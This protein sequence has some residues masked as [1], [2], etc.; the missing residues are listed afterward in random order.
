MAIYQPLLKVS[1]LE[2]N[3]SQLRDV[4]AAKV[5]LSDPDGEVEEIHALA[6]DTRTPKQIVRDIESLLLVKFD[7]RIDYRCVSLAQVSAQDLLSYFKRPKLMK[8][9]Q[10]TADGLTVEV[11][12][13][14]A[15]GVKAVGSAQT[16]GGA[17]TP[18]RVAAL[19]TLRALSIVAGKIED[20][21][22]EAAETVTLAGRPAAVVHLSWAGNQQEERFLGISFTE[23]DV[24]HGAA[25]ATL[26]AVNRRFF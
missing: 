2:E 20:V 5:I 13:A 4:Y 25:R 15:D 7:T 26:D 11:C 23:P 8:V 19:A 9:K 10:N 3:L 21:E 22:L 24:A 6:S 16:Q 18:C 14:Y 17:Q 1:T 12:L